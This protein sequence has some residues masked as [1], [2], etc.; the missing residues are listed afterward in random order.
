[1]VAKHLLCMTL[2]FDRLGLVQVRCAHRRI[3]Q[4]RNQRRLYL[5]HPAGH[6]DQLVFFTIRYFEAHGPRLDAGQ[7][8]RMA[9]IDTE[10]TRLAW[11]NREVG[12]PGEDQL[13]RADNVDM[14]SD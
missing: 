5:Q 12:L 4:Y 7:Q 3:G 14:Y 6:I 11:K 8:R 2:C 1:M 9:R 10:L 13:L